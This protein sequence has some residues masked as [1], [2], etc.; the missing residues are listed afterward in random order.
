MLHAKLISNPQTQK[1]RKKE[2]KKEIKE[3]KNYDPI[4]FFL[5]DMIVQNLK[6]SW[7]G[8]GGGK[9]GEVDNF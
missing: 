9:E 4:A 8:V 6:C 1:K 3:F 5:H 2:K 7:N